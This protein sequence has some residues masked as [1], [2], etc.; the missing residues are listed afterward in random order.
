MVI[1]HGSHLPFEEDDNCKQQLYQKRYE[2][3]YDIY[4]ADYVKWLMENHP[5]DI[6]FT[7]WVEKTSSTVPTSAASLQPNKSTKS[8]EV[9]LNYKSV[10]EALDRPRKR[11][12]PYK[13]RPEGPEDS[14]K[15]ISKYLHQAVIVPKQKKKLIRLTGARVLTSEEA[16]KMMQEKQDAKQ[17][18]ALEKEKRKEERERKKAEKMAVTKEDTGK[19]KMPTQKS[20]G[21]M[22]NAQQKTRKG[23]GK[24]APVKARNNSELNT[25]PICNKSYDKVGFDIGDWMQCHCQQWVHEDCIT[26]AFKEPLICPYCV[27]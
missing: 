26:Y 13:S 8:N 12:L 17:K 5:D 2:E 3:G 23:K 16:M 7:E 11:P 18:Q 6:P 15:Y 21:K 4:D 19:Q 14:G 9:T 22:T 25:C 20:Y 1:P 10:Y 24:A 27:N